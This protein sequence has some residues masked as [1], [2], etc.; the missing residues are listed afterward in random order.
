MKLR[1]KKTG[2]MGWIGNCTNDFIVVYPVN[3]RWEACNDEKCVYFTISDFCEEWE[4]VKE[5]LIKDEKIR[6]AVRAWAEANDIKE[7]IIFDSSN[8]AP[9]TPVGAV[10]FAGN[11]SRLKVLFRTGERFD[12]DRIYTIGELC[13]EEK[14]RPV[15]VNDVKYSSY[16][17]YLESRKK[18]A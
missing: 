10:E 14:P 11:A 1:N 12:T 13:G 17:D 9:Y 7:I 8:N 5:P 3:E 2:K 15:I 6:K 4:D 18:K 16:E